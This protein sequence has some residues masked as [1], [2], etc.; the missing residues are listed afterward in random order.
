MSEETLGRGRVGAASRDCP[1]SSPPVASPR[2]GS[3]DAPLHIH[4]GAAPLALVAGRGRGHL[5]HAGAGGIAGRPAARER[6]DDRRVLRPHDP[7]GGDH[8]RERVEETPRPTRA[9]GGA[10]PDGGLRD[11]G[12]QDGRR[13][14]IYQALRERARHGAGVRVPALLALV[15][16]ALLGWLDEGIQALLPNR[17]Y[18]NFDVLSNAV[19]ALIGIAG[20]VVVGRVNAV[21]ERR[22]GDC[23][24]GGWGAGGAIGLV[25]GPAST[26]R[27]FEKARAVCPNLRLHGRLVSQG[28]SHTHWKTPV[29]RTAIPPFRPRPPRTSS[30][31]APWCL[32]PARPASSSSDRPAAATAGRTCRRPTSRG[33]Y[34]MYTKHDKL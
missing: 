13:S 19:A 31:A 21:V 23:W 2:H 4:S 18:D 33:A 15:V 6:P 14:G 16:T 1:T 25:P 3:P 26:G 20:S 34:A 24:G 28:P 22:G 17:V 32:N 30:G 27:P 8:R 29:R 7:H 5:L 10:R 9:M 12:A 11:G